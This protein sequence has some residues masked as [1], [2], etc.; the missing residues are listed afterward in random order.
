[1]T[2][3]TSSAQPVAPAIGQS[4]GV[5]RRDYI[6]ASMLSIFL[7]QLGVDRFYMGYT[8]LGLLK[9]FTLGGCG[10]WQLIDMILVL[11]NALR[12]ADGYELRNYESNKKT[13]W[14][15]ALVVWGIGI[16]GGLIGIGVRFIVAAIFGP[17]AL[18]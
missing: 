8:A 18:L 6:T 17:E 3:P 16:L 7:G 2:T 12:D 10:V 15:I 9:L 5:G 13:A 11:T 1:M 4:R 14:I